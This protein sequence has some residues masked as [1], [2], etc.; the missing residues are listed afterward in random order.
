MADQRRNDRDSE[1]NDRK[2]IPDRIKQR[3][4]LSAVGARKFP[5]QEIGIKQKDDESYLG[6]CPQKRRHV[7]WFGFFHFIFRG[8]LENPTLV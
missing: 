8:F 6:N 2:Y 5:H 4:S 1:I 3:F 7:F